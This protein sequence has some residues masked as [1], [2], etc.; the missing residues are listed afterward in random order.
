MTQ[1]VTKDALD[2]GRDESLRF[3]PFSEEEK[4]ELMMNMLLAQANGISVRSCALRL[5][6]N[7]QTKLLRYQNKYRNLLKSNPGMVQ[8]VMM[9]LTE[10]GMAYYNPYTRQVLGGEDNRTE[11]STEVQN[12]EEQQ[13]QEEQQIGQEE[14]FIDIV[15]E[16]IKNMGTIQN[17]DVVRLFSGIRNLTRLAAYHIYSRKK[18]D[19]YD[20]LAVK[21]DLLLI[22][23]E[24]MEKEVQ[25][26]IEREENWKRKYEERDTE[27]NQYLNLIREL[28]ESIQDQQE[29]PGSS[30]CLLH[31]LMELNRKF[32]RLN[33]VHKISSLTGYTS[34]LLQC[35]TEYERMMKENAQK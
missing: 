13:P 34:E 14:N 9:Q 18:A 17:E 28:E 27:Q 35:M 6:N 5:G 23:A 29:K 4:I 12:T 3:I 16:I 32:I 19:E 26:A 10:K 1:S 25:E 20:R 7:D 15:S 21:Y 31:R 8:N 11:N 33:P 24:K 2:E 30:V 22:E